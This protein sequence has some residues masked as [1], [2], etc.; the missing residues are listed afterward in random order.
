MVVGMHE[1]LPWSLA[2][3]HSMNDWP[4]GIKSGEQ[5]YQDLLDFRQQHEQAGLCSGQP[6]SFLYE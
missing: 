4:L 2:S 6:F 3:G 1:A 5:V